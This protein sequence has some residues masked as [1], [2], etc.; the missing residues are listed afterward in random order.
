MV[1]IQVYRTTDVSLF[2]CAFESQTPR[3]DDGDI[4]GEHYSMHAVG[5]TF[6]QNNI[7]LHE[8][9]SLARA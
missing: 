9:A 8:L 6:R 4:L 2:R 3:K 7:F 5:T 1:I